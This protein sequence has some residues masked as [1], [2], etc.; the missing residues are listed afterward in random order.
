M[1]GGFLRFYKVLFS[2][3]FGQFENDEV[4]TQQQKQQDCSHP[5][6]DLDVM[7]QNVC[8]RNPR[9]NFPVPVVVVG[10]SVEIQSPGVQSLVSSPIKPHLDSWVHFLSQSIF[11]RSG[12]GYLALRSNPRSGVT[13]PIS[14]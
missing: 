12:E 14:W 10:K 4:E 1:S 5:Y 13:Q 6:R 8:E 2:D 3:F 7:V 9:G 11:L